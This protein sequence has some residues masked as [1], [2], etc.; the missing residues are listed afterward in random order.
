M[1]AGIDYGS[2]HA[3]VWTRS[4]THMARCSKCYHLRHFDHITIDDDFL[5]CIDNCVTPCILSEKVCNRMCRGELAPTS[6]DVYDMEKMWYCDCIGHYPQGNDYQKLWEHA[7][8]LTDNSRDSLN[9]TS[10]TSF[11]DARVIDFRLQWPTLRTKRERRERERE[12][13]RK[14]KREWM[15]SDDNCNGLRYSN[16]ELSALPVE[17]ILLCQLKQFNVITQYIRTYNAECRTYN[18]YFKYVNNHQGLLG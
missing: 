18:L 9:A 11:W 17:S 1:L 10:F 2:A 15:I 14:R 5:K 7:Y 12:R 6:Q 13:E 4:I 16:T 3:H 8:T